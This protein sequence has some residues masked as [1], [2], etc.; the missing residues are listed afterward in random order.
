M[1]DPPVVLYTHPLF[2]E[3]LSLDVRFP[4]TRYRDV[5]DEVRRRGFCSRIRVSPQARRDEILTAHGAR[6]LDAFLED[7]LDGTQRR[8]IGLTPW[9]SAIIPRTLALMGGSLAA[10][11]AAWTECGVAGHMAG[12]THHAHRNHGAGYCIFND[13]PIVTAVAQQRYGVRRVL[14][15]DLDV[16]QGDGTAT[17]MRDWKGALTFSLHCRANF[18]FRKARSHIDVS[19]APGVGDDAYFATL[20]H[21]VPR[22]VARHRPEL[23]I[24]QAG[25]DP[26][27]ADHLGRLQLS[28]SGLFRRN[29][30]VFAET[31]GRRIPTVVLMGGG[32]AK[33]ID[34]SVQSH[35]DVFEE[36]SRW[37]WVPG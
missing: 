5:H 30:F 9:T 14:V 21:H 18:P 28:R 26:L 23:V 16:H 10:L 15:I 6:Y 31:A 24:F 13:I 36:A 2:T 22:L 4:R 27:A 17:I 25:V 1:K 19:L 33:P 8:R 34:A 7:R 37:T 35:A 29:R 3:A 32:Y 11:D 12:G 20:R